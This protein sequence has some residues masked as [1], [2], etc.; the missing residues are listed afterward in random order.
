MYIIDYILLFVE[1]LPTLIFNIKYYLWW[2]EEEGEI[3]IQLYWGQQIAVSRTHT[4]FVV[5]LQ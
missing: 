1:T 4:M 5:L 3:Y 2:V